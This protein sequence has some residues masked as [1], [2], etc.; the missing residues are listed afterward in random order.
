[1]KTHII[2]LI[3][4]QDFH[5]ILDWAKILSDKDRYASLEILMNLKPE[6]IITEPRPE[7]YNAE[8]YEKYGLVNSIIT[9]MKICCVRSKKDLPL[10]VRADAF[11]KKSSVV[12]GYI[13]KPGF[14]VEPIIKYFEIYPP[15][16]LDEIV[17]HNSKPRQWSNNDFHVLWNLYKH[18]WVKFDEEIFVRS[19]FI[20]PM[21]HRKTMED[22]RF[23]TDNPEA[24]EKVLMQFYKYEI[25]ILDISKWHA[26]DKFCCKKCTEYWDE[27]FSELLSL[28]VLQDRSIIRNLLSTLTF[29]WKKGHLDWHIRLL[30]LFNATK[31]EYLFNQDY[32]LAAL[33]STSNSVCN[34]VINTVDSL[35]KEKN[36][37]TETFFRNLPNLFVKEK[38]DKAIQKALDIVDYLSKNNTN[39]RQYAGSISAALMQPN[40]KI[41]ESAAHILKQYLDAESLKLAVEPF[42]SSLKQK[43]RDILEIQ[44]EQI[45]ENT[46]SPIENYP[47]EYPTTWEDF[48]F[49]VGKAIGSLDAADIDIMYN[50]FIQLQD[51]F[52]EKYVTQLKP[53][54]KKVAKADSSKELLVYISEFFESWLSSDKE[55][56]ITNPMFVKYDRNPNPFMR[57]RNKWV[58]DKLNRGSKLSLLSTPTHHPFYV[59]PAVLV[60]RLGEYE[61][62]KEQVPM[63]DLIVACNRILKTDIAKEVK[64]EAKKLKGYYAPA[65]QY[66]LGIS[67]KIDLNKD[68]LPL[69]TQVARTKNVDGIFQ[70][71]EKSE[72]KDYPAVVKP[73]YIPYEIERRYSS[74]GEYHWDYIVL[75]D[76]WNLP[77][78]RNKEKTPF[79]QLHFYTAHNSF[80]YYSKDGFRYWLSLIP[81]YCNAVL[82]HDLPSTASGNEVKDFDYCLFPLQYIIE[83]QIWVYHSGW[84]YIALCLIFE[85]KVSRTLAAEYINMA[86][87]LGFIN[88]EY[89]SESISVMIMNK[90]AP[91]NRLVEYFDM[92]NPDH[93]KQ[94]QLSIIEKC[95]E[96]SD[97][98]NLPVNFKKLIAYYKEICSSL[99]LK[100]NPN[101]ET[102]L[103][104]LKK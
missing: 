14:G 100:I 25:P 59:H 66:L 101:I 90:F 47:L 57:N 99:G 15:D 19:L 70:E 37:D 43:A 31:E 67:D 83:N 91:V 39:L 27:V 29:N 44:N 40:D 21:S 78:S 53:F 69:W 79:P 84:L 76:L 8:Y 50:G 75:D 98:E 20:I 72:A 103:Q 22:V 85:K 30:K 92:V 61:K 24:I 34:F 4:A 102:K 51:K 80:A 33:S 86:Y 65:I 93:I 64:D 41:Q 1:M 26:K 46:I 89:L 45:Q 87:G 68:T 104:S 58:L 5:K 16:Y 77:Y 55:Y 9:Y 11:D 38:S 49:H 56:K 94:L 18:D 17:E 28:E 3:L 62:A 32:L 7:K 60:S 88:E 54:I 42:A 12:N 71:F 23:L 36:F 81:H 97:K 10:T 82:L 2:E 52:P 6:E 35:Y 74:S 95:I 73:F 96:K 13:C 63:E 48:L